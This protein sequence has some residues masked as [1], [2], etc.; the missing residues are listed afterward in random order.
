MSWLVTGGAGDIGLH[1]VRGPPSAREDV[2]VLDDLSTGREKLLTVPLTEGDVGDE[3]LLDRVM[4][5]H[6][7][8][9][10]VHLAARKQVA[11]SVAR[12]VHYY[13]ENVA[14]LITLLDAMDRH[15]VG[16]L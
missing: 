9:G 14:K 11:E 6:D 5:E 2:V 8:Q 15:G 7:I 10:V 12:P 3:A 13:R 4:T 1:V 16:V